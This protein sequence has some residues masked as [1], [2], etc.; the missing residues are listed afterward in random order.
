VAGAPLTSIALLT[1]NRCAS[2]PRARATARAQ[3]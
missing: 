3:A 1:Y 2:L